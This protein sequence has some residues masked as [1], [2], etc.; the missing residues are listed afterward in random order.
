MGVLAGYHEI[1]VKYSVAPCTG[2][3]WCTKPPVKTAQKGASKFQLLFEHLLDAPRWYIYTWALGQPAHF[4]QLS[5]EALLLLGLLS[6]PGQLPSPRVQ[7][8]DTSAH[9]FPPSPRLQAGRV[10]YLPGN[11][12]GLSDWVI[13]AVGNNH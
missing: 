7:Q 12:R 4:P 1:L 10:N 2:R 13:L 3:I 9:A 5:T 11:S 8:Q 6:P